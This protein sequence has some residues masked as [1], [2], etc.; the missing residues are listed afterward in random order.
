MIDHYFQMF[1]DANII[2]SETIAADSTLSNYDRHY[3]QIQ[4][5]SFVQ[6][7]IFAI[8]SLNII[9]DVAR[10]DATNCPFLNDFRG[11]V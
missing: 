11:V 6:S 4:S 5:I 1:K 3:I 7:Y 9:S 2:N 10:F 8:L